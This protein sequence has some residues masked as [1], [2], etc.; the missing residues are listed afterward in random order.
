MDYT[1]SFASLVH[2]HDEEEEIWFPWVF[3]FRPLVLRSS[4]GILSLYSFK[5]GGLNDKK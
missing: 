2:L 3:Q 1:Y 4:R 5:S